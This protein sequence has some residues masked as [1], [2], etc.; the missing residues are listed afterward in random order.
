[1][2]G[3]ERGIFNFEPVGPA[4]PL[5]QESENRLALILV[6][7]NKMKT[8]KYNTMRKNYVARQT[9]DGFGNRYWIL[10]HEGKAGNL[11]KGRN[12]ARF[13]SKSDALAAARAKSE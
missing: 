12:P 5:I 7:E 8:L 9:M 2:R 1:M 10:M 3:L 4:S 13:N 6:E 11:I